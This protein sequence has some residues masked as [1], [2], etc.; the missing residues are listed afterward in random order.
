[1]SEGC[2]KIESRNHNPKEG[3][4][5]NIAKNLILC[6][7]MMAAGCAPQ[8]GAPRLSGVTVGKPSRLAFG[9]AGIIHHACLFTDDGRIWIFAHTVDK[10]RN[11]LV[12]RQFDGSRWSAPGDVAD[13]GD[14][15]GTAQ[16]ALAPG[17]S[18]SGGPFLLWSVGDHSSQEVR[19]KASFW[20]GKSWTAPKDTPG[21]MSRGASRLVVWRAKPDA[22]AVMYIGE[23]R[24]R[25]SYSVGGHGWFTAKPFYMEL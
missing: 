15:R 18:R 5:L 24:P 12:C 23:L 2:G 4:L 19:I 7:M 11:R 22:W 14:L 1:M 3:D 8:T 9:A 10:D 13:L 21:L 16:I 25:E 6:V 17:V 20:D